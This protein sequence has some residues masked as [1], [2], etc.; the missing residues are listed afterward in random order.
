VGTR[1]TNPDA[2]A[3]M[4][5]CEKGGLGHRLAYLEDSTYGLLASRALR[6]IG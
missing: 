2:V 1:A 4:I 6:S 3:A 5:W